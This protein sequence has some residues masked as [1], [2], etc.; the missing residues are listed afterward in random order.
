MS[1]HVQIQTYAT[2]T[3]QTLQEVLQRYQNVIAHLR[4]DDPQ[5]LAW[6]SQIEWPTTDDDTFGDIY[7][8]PFRL[9]TDQKQG[10]DCIGMSISFYT[11]L[12]VPSIETLPTWIGFNLLFDAQSLRQEHTSAYTAE[13]GVII[14]H[15]M[16]D[17]AKSFRE[18]GVYFTD[19]WQDN[20]S[21]RVLSEDVGDPWSFDLAIFP[22]TQA[23][24]FAV[25]PSGFQGTLVENDF[26]FAQE[27]RWV[28]LP[29]QTDNS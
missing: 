29:W 13:A 3:Q 26:C 27:N 24:H 20:L 9:T 22:R 21:W 19:S 16:S 12:A 7:A 4:C 14:W 2:C 10:I 6:I 25:V 15:I 11:R 23:K 28:T 5:A 17:L 1:E 18:I 8:A